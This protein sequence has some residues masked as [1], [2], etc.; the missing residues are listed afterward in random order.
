[1][2][3]SRIPGCLSAATLTGA[4]PADERIAG[5]SKK[6]YQQPGDA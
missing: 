5:L 3:R 2:G 6:I 1:M 4:Y